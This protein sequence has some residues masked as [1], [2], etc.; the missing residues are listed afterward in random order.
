VLQDRGQEARSVQADALARALLEHGSEIVG[1]QD[2]TGNILYINPVVERVLGYSAGVVPGTN[3][4]D[5]IHPDDAAAVID[6]QQSRLAVGGVGPGLA[7]R[8]RHADGSWRLLDVV[9]TNMLDDPG[10]GA[11][12]FIARDVT[13][14]RAA[15]RDLQLAEAR[16]LALVRHSSDVITVLNA[17]GSWRSSSPAGT[18]LLGYPPGYDPVG[19]VLSLVHPD[20][21]LVAE[22]ALGEVFAGTRGP[23]APVVF[24]VRRTDGEYLVMETVGQNLLHD[25]SVYGVILNS[26]DITERLA[27]REALQLE[28]AR[29]LETLGRLAGG[30]AH[31]VNTLIGVMSIYL[32]SLTARLDQDSPLHDDAS[33]IRAAIAQ[34]GELTRQL[35]VYGRRDVP[36]AEVF[37]PDTIVP[38]VLDTVRVTAD[39]RI[40]L[41]HVPAVPPAMV[42]M[43][44]G[45]L[46]QA[47]LNVVCNARDAMPTGGRISIETERVAVD[48]AEDAHSGAGDFVELR[49]R[50]TGEGMTPDVLAAAC[51]PF[52]TTRANVGGTGLGLAIVQGFVTDAG[53]AV[54]IESEPGVGTVVALIVPAADDLSPAPT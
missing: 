2:G 7:V 23:D 24:R 33:H 1:L 49:V 13:E 17:D 11:V 34:A 47:L 48:D 26:R 46:E 53:G 16:S 19:G 41:V 37:D 38:D 39:D 30:V 5:F 52:F 43:P 54:R 4:F 18:R 14:R 20:D 21:L 3:V 35:L 36:V 15:E 8:V 29:R 31:D 22:A 50:D 44:R 32:N 42:M 28:R 6:A 9:S 25:P 27:A 45:Q 51:E 40:E 12:L 10:V